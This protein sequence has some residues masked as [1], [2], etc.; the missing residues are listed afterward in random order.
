MKTKNNKII[1][2]KQTK[3]NKKKSKHLKYKTSYK[4]N[5]KTF[6]KQKG[7]KIHTDPIINPKDILKDIPEDN[8]I[9]KCPEINQELLTELSTS[10]NASAIFSDI[11][12]I[13]PLYNFT[14][15]V[16]KNF[17][18]KNF[19]LKNLFGN[20]IL[21]GTIQENDI[22]VFQLDEQFKINYIGKENKSKAKINDIN[23]KNTYQNFLYETYSNFGDNMCVAIT[24]YF[25][26]SNVWSEF[27][28]EQPLKNFVSNIFYKP[29]DN[30]NYIFQNKI[31]IVSIMIF[32][33]LFK[34]LQDVVDKEPIEFKSIEIT[35]TEKE[36]INAI[37]TPVLT[38]VSRQS[39]RREQGNEPQQKKKPNE[40]P[41]Q[42]TSAA[43]PPAPVQ[44]QAQAQ[45]QVPIQVQVPVQ[46][47]SPAQPELNNYHIG[48]SQAPAETIIQINSEISKFYKKLIGLNIHINKTDYF[49]NLEQVYTDGFEKTVFLKLIFENIISQINQE[50]S[51]RDKEKFYFDTLVGNNK[52]IEHIIKIFIIKNKIN[53]N[54]VKYSILSSIPSALNIIKNTILL[55]LGN[56]LE[57][58][59]LKNNVTKNVNNVNNVNNTLQDT[60]SLRLGNMLANNSTNDKIRNAYNH[61]MYGCNYLNIATYV[62][63]LKKT[64]G[65]TVNAQNTS[66]K[67][68]AT[69]E[70]KKE[71]VRYIGKKE[72]DGKKEQYIGSKGKINI[73]N[74][75]FEYNYIYFI[76]LVIDLLITSKQSRIKYYHMFVGS[77]MLIKELMNIYYLNFIENNSTTK[78][79]FPIS[80]TEHIEKYKVNCSN[81][82]ISLTKTIKHN[83]FSYPL[84]II[85]W[86]NVIIEGYSYATCAE[87]T[88]LNLLIYLL[89]D[90]NVG[91][92]TKEYIDILDREYPQH[93]LEKYF[94]DK[95]L[96]SENIIFTLENKLFEFAEELT[97]LEHIKYLQGGNYE[98]DGQISNFIKVVL[99][100]LGIEYNKTFEENKTAFIT[101]TSKFNKKFTFSDNNF[102]SEH[103][104]TAWN[105]S[106]SHI[107]IKLLSDY[108]TNWNLSKINHLLFCDNIKYDDTRANYFECFKKISHSII[109]SPILLDISSIGNISYHKNKKIK[110]NLRNHLSIYPTI[111]SGQL[112]YEHK[113][114]LLSLTV[115][116]SNVDLNLI[117]STTNYKHIIFIDESNF[118]QPLEKGQFPE[119]EV[120]HFGK[121]FDQF[122]PLSALP[123]CKGII[124]T[125]N[126][127]FSRKIVEGQFPEAEEIYF[128]KNFNESIDQNALTKCKKI[129]FREN[130]KFNKPLKSRQFPQVEEICFG[131]EFNESIHQNA[132]PNCKKIIFIEE[133]KFNKELTTG[134]FQKVEE[135]EF[136][137]I[138]NQTINKNALPKCKK[139]IFGK[140]F[141]KELVAGQFL[142]VEEIHFGKNFN[143]NIAQSALPKC[144]KITF[145]KNSKFDQPIVEGQFPEVDKIEFGNDFKQVIPQSALPKC[146]TILFFDNYL[147]NATLDLDKLPEKILFV[148]NLLSKSVN[149]NF[150]ITKFEN[151]VRENFVV[152][153]I[154]GYSKLVRV[155]DINRLK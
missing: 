33:N 21:F 94:N 71:L 39:Q 8:S 55:P 105:G 2:I 3:N 53:K 128:G 17:R 98:V 19:I 64:A 61:I 14:A 92:I 148:E 46:N 60:V 42:N 122:I 40:T 91:K 49:N 155:R 79:I 75:Y 1:S 30:N 113:K 4:T 124:F 111:F 68:N 121:E 78:K 141:N 106:G 87:T 24:H 132:L 114:F 43:L 73:E 89:C 86:N 10:S 66:K 134:H 51:E 76:N 88:V 80:I 101:V 47:T 133:S 93:K 9:K 23:K 151:L 153:W 143:S 83:L 22:Y 125:V 12:C 38:P 100:V 31:N 129:I 130:S 20:I 69:A 152:D 82:D 84:K 29:P 32:F 13:C 109:L 104:K 140:N 131:N 45:A 118:N 70:L 5:Y 50:E 36:D 107:D 126:S 26:F 136:G 139:I 142:K 110:Q 99:A 138:F 81:Q 77:D 67:E 44:A 28:D 112:L 62:N 115:N 11:T 65:E 102:H 146:K 150:L 127:N 25:K 147:N 120:I 116:Q 154:S 27:Y 18:T 123:K 90:F 7:G 137:D 96:E 34:E 59:S 149:I 117:S 58:N 103:I 135:I 16:E 54:D 97:K 95:L 63:F 119:V 41:A 85:P 37:L 144:K 6:K 35:D 56:M 57:E 74:D 15:F 72:N 52:V 48:G 108:N 145:T